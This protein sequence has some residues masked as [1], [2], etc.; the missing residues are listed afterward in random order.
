MK[1]LPI[2]ARCDSI[3]IWGLLALLLCAVSTQLHAGHTSPPVSVAIAGS[4]QDE[5]GCPG[6]WQPDCAATELT[7][8]ARDAVWRG[9]YSVPAG[10]WEYKAALNDS[11]DENYG[12]N[13]T[14]DGANIPLSL[15]DPTDVRFYYDHDSHWV[16]DS[17]NAIIA[18]AA[19]S[20]QDELGC[21][22]DWQPD[23]LRSWLQDPDGD[24]LYGFVT[25]DL[26]A[27]D[28]EAKV[29]IDEAWDESYGQG[30]I[31]GGA[32][33]PF[34]VAA[35]AIV[36]FEYDPVSHILTISSIAPEP[37]DADYAIIHYYR[38]DG[39][40]GDHTT[41]DFND[42]WGL[43]LFGDGIA[44]EEVTDWTAP[45]PFLG[46]DEYGRFAWVRLAPDGGGNVGFIVH[47]GDTKDGTN[48][49]RFFDSRNTPEIWLKQD[50]GSQYYWQAAGQGYVT[51]RY[52]RP[53]GDYGDPTSAD[54]NDF[55]GVH[56]W[57]DAIDPSEIT[58][59]PS[60]KRPD[61]IDDYGAFFNVLLQDASL[62]V[63]FILHRGDTKDPGPDQSFVPQDTATAWV[64]SG[65]P[66]VYRQRGAAE[67]Y[68]TIHYHRDDGD[69]G[70]PTS[71][72]FND[73]WGLHVWTG[74]ASP[75]PAWQDPVRPAG[76]DLFGIFFEV[77]LEPGAPGLNYILHRGDIKDP[78]PDQFLT[79][80]D[81]GYEVWQ[82]NDADPLK[83]YI[84][85][86]P[87]EQTVPLDID[88]EID[89]LEDEG[90]LSAGQANSLRV[91]LAAA[92][93]SLEKGNNKT[94][95]NQL[96]AFINHVW[97]L[98]A[99]GVLPPEEGEL[100]VQLAEDMIM[101]IS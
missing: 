53:D 72:D 17:V 84:L 78:G 34:T 40:Y 48:A 30:G 82:L 64:Q 81:D 85:P 93:N 8:A 77:P 19:G 101:L 41:G 2:H 62:P 80:A 46:E 32:N 90:V 87:G 35:G 88:D 42:Y 43:H 71:V 63:N 52:H 68:A 15:S 50:D 91:K 27:G 54:F 57:G 21:P 24:G 67:G 49:D 20:F 1:R 37:V 97:S 12:A 83:P 60:P 66:E 36:E 29:A 70:D 23:C 5:L 31:P 58:E 69:Y 28:Y 79:L 86:V 11:W 100:L 51:I 10:D 74:A 95:I 92:E 22:G 33:I 14:Q 39:D 26:P 45:K 96:N 7:E 47:R 38:A 98:V 16:T 55:W 18:T 59:W 6:D 73:F 65:D 99:E 75:N 94:A 13:A 89:R 44:P 76:A 3:R 25:T 61:G 9:T 4:L 56:L